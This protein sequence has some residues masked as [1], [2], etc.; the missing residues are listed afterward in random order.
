VG[1]SDF[2]LTVPTP[3]FPAPLHFQPLRHFLAE[4]EGKKP[5]ES[6][7]AGKDYL[8]LRITHYA[9]RI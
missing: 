8:Q 9:L 7:W 5:P 2:Q 3:G 1:E 6:Q 4:I